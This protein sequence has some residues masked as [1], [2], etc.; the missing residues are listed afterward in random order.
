MPNPI[1]IESSYDVYDNDENIK[2]TVAGD[3]D[4]IGLVRITNA[5]DPKSIEW[6]GN[7]EFTMS[8]E[9]AESVAKAILMK[10]QDIRENTNE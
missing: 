5:N 4:A 3:K 1:S 6:F 2:I 8:I 10:V 7:I 9:I